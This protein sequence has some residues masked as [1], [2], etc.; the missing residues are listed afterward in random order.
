MINCFTSRSTAFFTIA[1]AAIGLACSA[2][3]SRADLTKLLLKGEVSKAG[4]PREVLP[5]TSNPRPYRQG[6]MVNCDTDTVLGANTCVMAFGVV[7]AGRL[8]QIDRINCLAASAGAGLTVFNTEIKINGNRIVGFV[9]PPFD[10]TLGTV[11]SG[12]Y[13]FNA[14]ERPLVATSAGLPT[15]RAICSIAGIMYQTS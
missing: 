4:T 9:L 2:S 6:L 14:G 8:L 1:I 3:T 15:D 10:S 12:P 5:P 13:Y 11:A 7:P